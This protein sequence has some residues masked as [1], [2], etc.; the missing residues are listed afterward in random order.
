MMPITY[1]YGTENNTGK[2][3]NNKLA[4]CLFAD[5]VEYPWLLHITEKYHDFTLYKL[6]HK[7]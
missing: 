1:A 3:L 6:T 7:V 5:I 4:C 2:I